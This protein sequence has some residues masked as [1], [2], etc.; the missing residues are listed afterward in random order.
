MHRLRT[1][2]GPEGRI[3]VVFQTEDRTP[4]RGHAAPVSRAGE[5]AAA[6]HPARLAG[7][8]QAFE[9]LRQ[10]FAA[11]PRAYRAELDG[12]MGRMA[13][14][15]AGDPQMAQIQAGAQAA[16]TYDLEDQEPLFGRQAA[17]LTPE[18]IGRVARADADLFRFP[19]IFGAVASLFPLLSKSP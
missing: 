5:T 12:F 8:W 11:D 16:G 14:A 13:E 4:L 19:G 2:P 9:G 6:A 17:L 10:L 7:A 3:L 15:V 18:V 1:R